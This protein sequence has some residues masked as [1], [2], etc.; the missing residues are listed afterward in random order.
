M[1]NVPGKDF[2]NSMLLGIL[3]AVALSLLTSILLNFQGLELLEWARLALVLL[4]IVALIS[5]YHLKGK[6]ESAYQGDLS[7]RKRKDPKYSDANAVLLRNNYLKDVSG[8][9]QLR[10]VVFSIGL[11]LSLFLVVINNRSKSND[12]EGHSPETPTSTQVLPDSNKTITESINVDSA[13][14][15]PVLSEDSIGDSDSSISR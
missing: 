14:D 3:M 13:I 7:G 6:T 15:S 2:I 10:Q 8:K 4:S 12:S 11:A 5:Y 1:S 9:R